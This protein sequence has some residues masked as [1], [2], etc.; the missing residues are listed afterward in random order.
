MGTVPD[1]VRLLCDIATSANSAVSFESAITTALQRI[2]REDGWSKGIGWQKLED[3]EW[4]PIGFWHPV[5]D[6]AGSDLSPSC[7][8]IVG[9][10]LAAV[11]PTRLLDEVA[12]S[13][14]PCWLNDATQIS[15]CPASDAWPKQLQATLAFPV[16]IEDEVVA[17][18]QLYSERPMNR[19]E[20][21]S[22]AT[23]KIG[24]LLGQ[25]L[26][27]K[28]LERQIATIPDVERS[29][30]RQDLHDG[31]AQQ[32]AAVTMLAGSLQQRLI[33]EQSSQA[34]MATRVLAALEEAKLQ[35]SALARSIATVEAHGDDL[36]A[37][38]HEL[39]QQA[40][41]KHQAACSFE[42]GG[43]AVRADAFTLKHLVL[44]AQEAIH[45]LLAKGNNSQILVRLLRESAIVLEIS[46]QKLTPSLT[47]VE[48]TSSVQIM[49][50]HAHLIG[51]EF[52]IRSNKKDGTAIIC[53]LAP[54]PF[55]LI[56]LD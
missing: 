16:L 14:R 2:C 13:G 56:G 31:L 1:P 29:R 52:S 48:Q 9:R 41:R 36:V 38:L 21:F 43:P 4:V 22:D 23:H 27:R 47:Q 18:L 30:I 5:A 6:H 46:A 28:R 34:E 19:D 20:G 53:I 33:N 8:P 32:I 7:W 25:V 15:S 45:F 42:C 49:R 51:G 17:V 3:K 12:Q 39:T 37:A 11:M 55:D 44:I 35:T 50:A 26:H 10:K 54:Q 40:G 24:M